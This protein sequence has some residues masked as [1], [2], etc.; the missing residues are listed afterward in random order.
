MNNQSFRAKPRRIP[1]DAV[2][3]EVGFQ[4]KHHHALEDA[5]A[6]VFIA[7]HIGFDEKFI[8]LFDFSG[9]SE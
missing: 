2:A 1:L 7:N 8:K 3:A 9:I 5:M 4:F 6:C